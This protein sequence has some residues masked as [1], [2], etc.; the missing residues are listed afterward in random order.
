MTIDPVYLVLESSDWV[1]R[2]LACGIKLIQL[3]IKSAAEAEL[4]REIAVS[5][6]L[7]ARRGAQFVVNDHWRL[8]IDLGCAHVH[9]GQDDLDS[10]DLGALRA[11]G[12]R[13]G[14]STETQEEL[15]RALALGADSVALQ[16]IFPT[17]S[18]RFERPPQGLD[19][20]R[21]W[22]ERLRGKPLIAIGGVRLDDAEAVFAAG[23]DCVALIS[24]VTR[25]ADPE[26]RARAWLAATRHYVRV[27]A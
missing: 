12:V 19:R 15:E 7:C 8:A 23:A 16:P 24:D 5:R 13:V 26:Q 27:E 2:M 21:L 25:A 3:R 14:V 10:A 11:A 6:D 4:R 22:K 20:L 1:A 9:L 18:K 17:A